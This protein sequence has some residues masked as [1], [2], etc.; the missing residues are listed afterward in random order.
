MASIVG[1]HARQ[2]L[3]SRGNPTLEVDVEL[4]DGSVGRAAVP[5][6][7]ST[8]SHEAAELR[9]GDPERWGGKGVDHAIDHVNQEIAAELM[10]REAEDQA[11]IDRTLIQLDGTPDKSRLGANAVVGV[12]LAV[13]RAAARSLGVPLYRYLGG[14]DARLL[15]VPMLN[16][17][18]GGRHARNPLDVQEF[19][20][21]PSG[22]QRFS[23]ALRA[24]A[25]TY[26]ALRS[27]LAERG[28]STAVGDEGGFAPALETSEEVLDLLVQ[29]IEKAGYRPG[30]QVA[31]A[32]DVAASELG[33]GEKGYRL[34][35]RQRTVDELVRIYTSWADRYPL[36]TL[37]DGLGEE[38]WAGWRS[39]TAALGQR[40]QLIGDDIFVTRSERLRRGI[41]EQVANSILI[42]VNQVGTLTETLETMR[43]ARAHGY[44]T[45]VSH[46][47]GETPDTFIADL[48][49]ATSA[50]QL[51]TGAP[52]RGERIAKYNQLLR[53]EEELGESA[54]FAGAAS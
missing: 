4:E 30:E 16:V 17:V 19:M 49:V 31:L 51:K 21:V 35:G 6:G 42:K 15:P 48:A 45:V 47:S 46:R 41:R 3:D 43:L 5:S 12:S 18:N 44:R 28:L 32:V 29:A 10:G 33:D 24:A 53:I 2:I 20:L 8:G 14:A 7:A 26:Q 54:L 27:L 13:A 52:S 38:D 39:L 25:E 23:D 37:E 34:D 11:A 50:G 22:F 9:D 1:V 36:V 40:L